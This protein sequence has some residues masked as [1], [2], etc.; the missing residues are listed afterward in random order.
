MQHRQVCCPATQQLKHFLTDR[1]SE[2]KIGPVEIINYFIF[3]KNMGCLECSETHKI[4]FHFKGGL[5]L[6]IFLNNYL[7]TNL[8]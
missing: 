7:F 1:S 3:T 4:F 8:K 6:R 2:I 5:I